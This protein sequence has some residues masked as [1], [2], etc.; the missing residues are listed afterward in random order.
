VF[1]SAD[2]GK[3][4]GF[5][6]QVA[7]GPSVKIVRADGAIVGPTFH[8]FPDP[9][10]QWRNFE[11]HFLRFDQG[12]RRHVMEP[13]AV[14]VEGLP[15]DVSP[16][17][18]EGKW[19]RRW[20]A[21]IY[22]DSDPVEIDGR[23]LTTAYVTYQGESRYALV[24]LISEDGGR[25]WQYLSTVGG[26]DSVSGARE[27]PD[28]ATLV[29]LADG[30]VMCVMRVGS[31][32]EQLLGRAYSSD[33]GRTW[34]AIDRLP[35]F[36]VEPSMRRLQNGVIA[37]S[38]GRPGIY[39]WLSADARGKSWES[40]DVVA[41]HNEVMGEGHQIRPRMPGVSASDAPDQ[42]T[43]Y[44]ELVEV[45]PNQLLLVYDRTPFGWKPVPADSDERS[46]IYVLPI[47]VERV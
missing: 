27:G 16:S 2:G 23:I 15:R 18:H 20:M 38:T 13:W 10:G 40:V 29:Q 8:L 42:T 34:S 33:G 3:T 41:H 5:S 25:N 35:A 4:W 47:E 26:P 39:V 21:Q 9:P 45:S 43:A 31:G 32:K 37:L 24:A 17:R 22:L 7:Q 14:R 36:S 19:S 12:G 6:Y 1:L 46:R 28:E 30:D 11:G 44:T